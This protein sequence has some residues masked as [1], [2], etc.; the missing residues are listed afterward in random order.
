MSAADDY[1]AEPV[2]SR[3]GWRAWLAENHASAPGCWAVV[4]KK[5]S[6]GPHVPYDDIVEEA[7]AHG[8]VDSLGRRLDEARAMLLVTPRRPASAWSAANKRRIARLTEAGLMAEAGRAVVAA[9]KE[10]GT[11][12]ALDEVERLVEPGELRAALDGVPGARANWDAFPPS[13]RRAILGWIST[14]KRAPTRARRVEETAR[15]AGENVRANQWPRP[16]SGGG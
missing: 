8:W 5:G 16:K 3:A 10:S 9:A 1:P 6:G 14:A 11:W 13:A 15:L 7:L 2:E 4:W 12:S